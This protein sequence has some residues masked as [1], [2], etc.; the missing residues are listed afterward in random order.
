M[1][2]TNEQRN[3]RSG[4]ISAGTATTVGSPSCTPPTDSD[5]VKLR[6]TAAQA[7]LLPSS[8]VP[9]WVSSGLNS[10]AGDH[11]ELDTNQREIL[12]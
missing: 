2:R 6:L 5:P 3:R 9:A 10:E 1:T 12:C 4:G 11:R 7:S 8:S